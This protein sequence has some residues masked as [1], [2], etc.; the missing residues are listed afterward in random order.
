MA[1]ITTKLN[2]QYPLVS[3]SPPWETHFSSLHSPVSLVVHWDE[4]HDEH[5]VLHRVQAEQP[6]LEGGEHSATGLGHNHL[7][8]ELIELLPERL[9]LKVTH[10][11]AQPGVERLLAV[12]RPAL[13]L[14]HLVPVD[15]LLCRVVL[16]SARG[17]QTGC[18]SHNVSTED[19]TVYST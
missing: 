1:K 13:L 9:H 6:H 3:A 12:R 7:R 18:N 16:G 14:P 15:V 17:H 2:S 4:V 19:W 8:P 5:V 11:G 10:Y